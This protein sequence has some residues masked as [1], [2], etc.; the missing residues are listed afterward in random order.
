MIDTSAVSVMHPEVKFHK[1]SI[2]TT[3]TDQD[4]QIQDQELFGINALQDQ[5]LQQ[6][7]KDRYTDT[8][9]R[10]I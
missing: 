9:H 3:L 6:V 8:R 10:I 1:R 2:T 4:K 7:T 5:I